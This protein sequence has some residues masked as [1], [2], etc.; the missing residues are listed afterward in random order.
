MSFLHL[1]LINM[2]IANLVYHWLPCFVGH[3]IQKDKEYSHAKL[4]PL[5]GQLSTGCR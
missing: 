1:T 2:N 4:P 3:D 5:Q